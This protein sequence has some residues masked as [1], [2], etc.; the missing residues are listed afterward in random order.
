MYRTIRE[1]RVVYTLVTE[2]IDLSS[3]K[4]FESRLEG[5][6]LSLWR[7]PSSDTPKVVNSQ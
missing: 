2:C 4:K 3:V 1:K 7:R 5:Q 6:M